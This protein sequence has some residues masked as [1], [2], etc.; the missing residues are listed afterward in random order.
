VV[1]FIRPKILTG[2]LS[3]RIVCVAFNVFLHCSYVKVEHNK[4]VC[5]LNFTILV[6]VV[7]SFV[8]VFY[9]FEQ[10]KFGISIWWRNV[11]K[12]FITETSDGAKSSKWN[13]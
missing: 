9:F 11:W 5:C 10:R 6:F 8:E 4:A 1:F 7:G 12:C 2:F 3:N 13:L